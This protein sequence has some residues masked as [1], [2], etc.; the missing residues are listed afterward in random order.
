MS[1]RW[2]R[3]SAELRACTPTTVRS[4]SRAPPRAERLASEFGAG[5]YDYV[6]DA[7][8][9]FAVWRGAGRVLVV[10]HDDGFERKVKRAFP[11]AEIVARPRPRLQPYIRALRPH[12]WAKNL[13]VFMSLIVGHHFDAATILST[14]I[15]FGCFCAAR[16]ERL[17]S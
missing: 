17:S 7:S 12:Q 1:R 9:D 8:V 14:V 5:G 13:L 3:G 10:T 6:G 2:R 15:A 4:I 11:E 16:V